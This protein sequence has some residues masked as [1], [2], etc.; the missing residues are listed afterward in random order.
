MTAQ[1]PLYSEHEDISYLTPP[2]KI[3]QITMTALGLT[4]FKT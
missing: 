2:I 3:N 4:L 1:V